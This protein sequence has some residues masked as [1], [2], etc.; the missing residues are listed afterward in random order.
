MYLTVAYAHLDIL[1]DCVRTRPFPLRYTYVCVHVYMVT[2][3]FPHMYV[4]EKEYANFG[5]KVLTCSRDTLMFLYI[6]VCVHVFEFS[7]CMSSEYLRLA[8]VY[9]CVCMYVCMYV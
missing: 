5:G 7:M 9:V 1:C 2:R 8:C 6:C 3:L 4:C